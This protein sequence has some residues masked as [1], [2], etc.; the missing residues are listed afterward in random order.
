MGKYSVL[1][2]ATTCEALLSKQEF[3]IS[4]WGRGDTNW[5]NF[6]ILYLVVRTWWSYPCAQKCV[7]LKKAGRIQEMTFHEYSTQNG[8]THEDL[9]FLQVK[10]AKKRTYILSQDENIYFYLRSS[11]DL[12]PTIY[13][14][15]SD[16]MNRTT[17]KMIQVAYYFVSSA[18]TWSEMNDNLSRMSS[19]GACSA[20]REL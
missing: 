4:A 17:R 20:K 3:W 15:R 7:R 9:R 13:N 12:S 18:R 2:S 1:R 5:R 6:S 8:P 14:M 16:K 11:K 10:N 19:K